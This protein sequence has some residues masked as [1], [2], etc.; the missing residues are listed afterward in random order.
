MSCHVMSCHVTG[1]GQGVLGRYYAMGYYIN[2]EDSSEGGE[3]EEQWR[4]VEDDCQVEGINNKHC[5][6]GDQSSIMCSLHHTCCKVSVCEGV[7]V[8]KD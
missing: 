4:A 6:N 3:E 2:G 1:G 8:R 5:D 7:E